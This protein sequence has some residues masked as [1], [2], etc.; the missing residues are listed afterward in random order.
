MRLSNAMR[1]LPFGRSLTGRLLGLTFFGAMVSEAWI[2][3]PS[4]PSFRETCVGERISVVRDTAEAYGCLLAVQRTG[5]SHAI[6][7]I[8]RWTNVLEM[9]AG[10]SDQTVVPG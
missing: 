7:R 10:E 3:V 6:F 2:Y 9:P 4:I 8:E 1:C 5:D